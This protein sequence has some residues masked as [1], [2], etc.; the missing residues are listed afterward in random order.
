MHPVLFKIGNFAIYSYGVVIAFSV[1]WVSF[2]VLRRGRK[3][4]L[5]EEAL[6][7]IVFLVVII[8]LFGARLLH[9]LVHFSY[10]LHHPA[11][12]IAIRHGGMAAQGGLIFG[13]FAAIFFLRRTG[14]PTL[15]VLDYFGLYLPL[16]QA[17]GRIGCFLNGCCYGKETDFFWGAR[18]PFDGI[19][20]HP[21]QLYYSLSN[22][23]IFLILLFLCKQKK[24]LSPW[25]KDGNIV[26]FY[27]LLYSIS[28]YSIDFLRGNLNPVFFSLY[29][30]QVISFFIFLIAGG[31]LI[32]QLMRGYRH[33]DNIP[34]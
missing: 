19:S 28:R 27:F 5:N 23:S 12:V 17:I 26:I 1:L 30:T 6:L 3:E 25:A 7:N 34:G 22:F 4:G 11:E 10:Y 8:G 14:L 2:L 24:S 13:L 20:R 31:L 9:I 33:S 16:A 21:T 32:F 18:F 29:P 15:R